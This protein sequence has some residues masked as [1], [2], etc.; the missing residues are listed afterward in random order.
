MVKNSNKC[1]IML[2]E[3]YKNGLICLLLMKNSRYV[4]VFLM[5]KLRTSVHCVLETY[6]IHY[7]YKDLINISRTFYMVLVGNE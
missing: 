1:T 3:N 2:A 6:E 7:G 5:N 4:V